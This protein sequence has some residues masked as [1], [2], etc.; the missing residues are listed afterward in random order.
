MDFPSIE[1]MMRDISQFPADEQTTEMEKVLR[2]MTLVE[3]VTDKYRH[4]T[5]T[6]TMISVICK[7]EDYGSDKIKAIK[8]L[9]HNRALEHLGLTEGES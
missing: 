9:M 4:S 5:E 1:Q 2:L 3:D 6:L 8:Q 7:D